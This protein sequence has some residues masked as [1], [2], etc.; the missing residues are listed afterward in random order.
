M[1]KIVYSIIVL[2]AI[3]S[4][5]CQKFV[6]W[7]VDPITKEVAGDSSL[8]I[9]QPS[10]VLVTLVALTGNE[11]ITTAFTYDS[12]N[13]LIS[14]HSTGQQ[15]G[16]VVDDYKKFYRD[17]LG[18]IVLVAQLSG[19]STNVTDT[20]FTNV[21]Y[22]ED[23]PAFLRTVGTVVVNGKKLDDSTLYTYDGNGNVGMRK[24]YRKPQGATGPLTLQQRQEFNY[25]NKNLVAFKDFGD[26]SG[27]LLL[28]ENCRY[29]FDNR[30]NP[31][32]LYNEA[33]LTGRIESAS[34]NNL[35]KTEVADLV[36]AQFN[37]QLT[38]SL[39]YGVKSKPVSGI[40]T[41]A[42]GNISRLTFTY[43]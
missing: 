14:E 7:H 15:N 30:V 42:N 13:Q 8:Y 37:T 19:L 27:V 25:Q 9:N 31:L 39:A 6:E 21:W 23:E 3:C 22:D 1:K 29:Q 5:S 2:I 4:F 24:S 18:R 10:A 12:L 11:A 32:P 17:T 34:K 38:N 20:L 43:K 16:K 28:N 33:F 36:S 40:A 26:S 41:Y 35:V